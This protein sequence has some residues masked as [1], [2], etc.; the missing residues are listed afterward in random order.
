MHLIIAEKNIAAHRIAQILSGEKNLRMGKEGGVPTYIFEDTVVVGLKGHVVDVDFLPEYADWRS[1]EYT[2]R[3]LI[4]APIVKK[5][6]EKKIVDLIR[7]LGKKADLVTIAT[8][9]DTEGELIGK[10]ACEIIRS[11]NKRVPMLRARF[12]A[13]T[14]QEILHAFQQ[15]SVL[16]LA[17]AAAGEARQEIDLVW[18]ASLTRFISLAARR[19]GTNI[20]SVGRVQSPT[21]AMIVD[22]EKEIESF[23][24]EPYWN[25]RCVTEKDRIVFEVEHAHGRFTQEEEAIAA[26]NRTYAPLV[27]T[28]IKESEKLDRPPAPFD[29]TAFIVAAGRIGFGAGKAMQIAEDLYMNG[30]I[31]YP[32]TDNTLYPKTLDISAILRTLRKTEFGSDVRWVEE[33]RRS[34]PTH[35]KK[36]ST[37]H[38]P[39]HPTGQASRQELGEDRWRVYELVV[40]RFLATLS[41]DA[42]WKMMKVCLRASEEPYIANGSRLLEPGW[43]KVYL[44][45]EAQEDPIP[46]LLEGSTLP[47]KD[48]ILDAKET[49]PPP[50]YS[51]SRLIQRME[52]LGL[53][54]KST[55]H[56]VVGKL[57]SRRYIQGNPVRPTLVGRAVIDALEDY[58]DTITK[59]EMTQTLDSHMQQIKEKKRTRK[60]VAEESR[61]MLQEIFQ[62]L[63]EHREDIGEEIREKIAE[64][65]A[66]GTCPVCGGTLR[67]RQMKGSGQ[68]IGCSG[69][70]RCTFNINL[71]GMQWGKAV[72]TETI[73]PDHSLHHVRLIRKGVRP[74][75]IGCALCTHI[76]SHTESLRLIPM[77]NESI[78]SRLHARHVYTVTDLTGMGG[79]RLATLLGLTPIEAER[80]IVEAQEALVLLRKRSDLRK[81][82]RN[83]LPPRRGRKQTE[84]MTRMYAAGINDVRSLAHTEPAALKVTGISEKEAEVLLA[85]GKKLCNDRI[86]RDIGI[87]AASRKKYMEANIQAPEELCN[88]PP[89]YV[90]HRTGLSLDTVMRHMEK[91]CTFIG[92]KVPSKFSNAVVERGRTGLLS[93][94]GLGDGMLERLY[95]AGIIGCED[96]VKAD[97]RKLAESTGIPESKIR[98]FI[99]SAASHC[100]G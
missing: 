36:E 93:L 97:P 75:E 50:R 19:G 20:L 25:L 21:L 30:Y 33:H 13:I 48:V 67:I 70:P 34:S 32:R 52:E 2:P 87:P 79:E 18:G 39:I 100:T 96:L 94:P 58:A 45:S 23:I 89:V 14:P 41:P 47:L 72:R 57:L 85:E 29:T 3:S 86:F 92:R 77:M 59:P 22:R 82:V 28:E 31:S 56:E 1:K 44:F 62:E 76:A 42:R 12:S 73:C 5:V 99:L 74:W 61:Y 7:K 66:L 68:F 10:E 16:D 54:T 95:Y 71:P 38:P 51:Q 11:G 27:V 55:R 43:R 4:D 88:L 84:I 64:E 53:G 78:L 24:P 63:E 81:F 98:E 17:L 90:S 8:D 35:G 40:R 37:D 83:H 46:S 80:L 60:D 91:T 6:T 49:Q 26:R 9:Y 65:H 69:Y 15:P